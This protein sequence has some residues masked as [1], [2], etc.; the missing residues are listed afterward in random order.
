M[1]P[2]YNSSQKSQKW[3]LEGPAVS[4]KWYLPY[5]QLPYVYWTCA[6]TNHFY[7]ILLSTCK[8]LGGNLT[9][10]SLYYER[11]NQTIVCISEGGPAT[12]VLWTKDNT[13]ISPLD[14]SSSQ[15]VTDRIKAIYENRFRIENK[16][17]EKT[18]M[19]MCTVSNVRSSVREDLFI[20]G[21]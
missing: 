6:Y 20:Q 12:T 5:L 16:T 1:H 9:I 8:F 13:I 21:M 18:G 4:S 7:S 14:Y 15:I 2:K 11:Q 17:L 10:V 3:S 19:Y